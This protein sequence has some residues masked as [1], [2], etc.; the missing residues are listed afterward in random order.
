MKSF[1]HLTLLLLVVTVFHISVNIVHAQRHQINLCGE[2]DFEQTEKAYPPKKF[3][4]KIAVPGLVDLAHPPIDQYDEL[5]M[6]D[7]DPKYSWYRCEFLVP[8]EQ[9][10]KKAILTLLKSRFN[11]QVILNDIDL[12]TYMECSTPIEC[13]LTKYLNTSP[14]SG[15]KYTSLLPARSGWPDR[16]VCLMLGMKR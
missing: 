13:D 5:F 2:W 10:G 16:C 14:A 15:M 11:T 1:R 4:R 8:P 9:V 7:H 12:G 6:G 3:T